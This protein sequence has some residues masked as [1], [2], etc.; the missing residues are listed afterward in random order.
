MKRYSKAPLPFNG[1]KTRWLKTFSAI[2][3]ET[4]FDA[5]VDLFGGSGLLSHT[6]KTIKPRAKV[7]YN[8]FDGYTQRLDSISKTNALLSDLRGILQDAPREGRIR[9][10]LKEAILNRIKSEAGY[11]DFPTLSACLLFTMHSVS[12]IEELSREALYNN[13]PSTPYN[14][15]GY[16]SGVE[17]VCTD[18]KELVSQYR[19]SDALFIFDPPYL[20][21]DNTRYKNAV[22]WTVKDYLSV[23]RAMR[24][25]DYIYFT[26]E[27]S[28]VEE[29]FLFLQDEFQAV[30]PFSGARKAFRETGKGSV[31]D[32]R[33][34][35]YCKI[36][37]E[38]IRNLFSGKFD[39]PGNGYKYRKQ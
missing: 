2:I 19:D 29:L 3:E 7:I 37:E 20:S 6:V 10:E 15:D 27:K 34:Y 13:V 31:V 23:V 5:C 38:K 8:D 14:A 32:Y 24:G 21:T 30:T 28:Q 33:E 25:V 39:P 18:Y 35:V 26:S 17:S 16:L 22:Y 9:E 36:R 1:Q 4:D 11:I 12:S